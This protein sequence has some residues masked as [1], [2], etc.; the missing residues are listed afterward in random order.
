[1]P[2]QVVAHHNTPRSYLVRDMGGRIL[3]R[4]Q[5]QINETS[6]MWRISEPATT[7]KTAE[8]KSTPETEKKRADTPPDS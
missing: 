4:N 6:E 2:A 5:S 8:H 3:R 7:N 1:M